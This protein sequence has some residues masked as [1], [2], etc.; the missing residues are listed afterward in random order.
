MWNHLQL[1]GARGHSNVFPES[2][3]TF[4]LS[5]LVKLQDISAYAH[6][7]QQKELPV[8][9]LVEGYSGQNLVKIGRLRHME[10]TMLTIVYKNVTGKD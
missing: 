8:G 6:F 7:L 4:T 10:L 9:D 1:L 5:I 2:E 3:G